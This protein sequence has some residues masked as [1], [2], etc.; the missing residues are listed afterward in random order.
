MVSMVSKRRTV[1]GI[2]K[3]VIT[4]CTDPLCL[5]YL[6]GKWFACAEIGCAENYFDFNAVGT[7]ILIYRIILFQSLYFNDF[8]IFVGSS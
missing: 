3:I 2:L 4:S 8:A 6:M 1:V 5:L 7:N